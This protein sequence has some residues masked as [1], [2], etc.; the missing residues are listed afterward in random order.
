MEMRSSIVIGG[1]SETGR[2]L[3]QLLCDSEE[4]VSVTVITPEQIELKDP[5]LT[6]KVR[7]IGE[8]EERDIEFAHEIFCCMNWRMKGTREE[9]EKMM[10]EYP[11]HI[12]SLAKKRGIMNFIL[13][14]SASA[15]KKSLFY[16]EQ[17]KGKLEEELI[18][19]ELPQISI[20]R[21]FSIQGEKH[22]IRGLLQSLFNPFLV[23]LLKKFRS[24][25]HEQLALSL[26]VVALYGK[27][28][29]VTE[30]SSQELLKMK[31]PEVEV[32]EEIVFNW[33]K[34]K[35]E[36]LGVVDREVVF[37]KK[38]HEEELSPVDEEAD[39]NAQNSNN[40]Q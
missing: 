7:D 10:I 26:M 22:G 14:S 32:E 11:L 15:N 6:V 28:A 9:Y 17:L 30:Y 8:V 12:A 35:E 4:Y 3:I 13:L 34:Y 2:A 23:G 38:R 29:P 16:D 18:S 25:E 39:S 24:F 33:D 36:D 19:L 1:T 5:K 31:M 27:K 21:P 37:H 20:I 40:E